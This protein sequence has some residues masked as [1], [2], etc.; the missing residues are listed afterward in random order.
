LAKVLVIDDQ[1]F[2]AR[3]MKRVFERGGYQVDVE[4]DPM[5]AIQKISSIG[6]DL[7]VCDTQLSR[8]PPPLFG[9]NLLDAAREDGHQVP[10]IGTSSNRSYRSEWESRGARFID[11]GGSSKEYLDVAEEILE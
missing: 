10:F 8:G 4:T 1:S 5:M 6:Y 9:Y 11:R 2:V 3:N 7:V